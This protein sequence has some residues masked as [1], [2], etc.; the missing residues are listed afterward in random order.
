MVTGELVHSGGLVCAEGVGRQVGKSE[1]V[2][3]GVPGVW[4]SREW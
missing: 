3:N 1:L 2:L 4:V